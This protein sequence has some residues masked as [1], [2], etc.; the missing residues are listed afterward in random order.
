ML[1]ASP[2]MVR[3][4]NL[5]RDSGPERRFFRPVALAI[6]G[7]GRIIILDGHRGRLQVYQKDN[8]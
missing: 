2:D 7:E 6:D 5:V 1:S 4:R 8:Y 3:Q